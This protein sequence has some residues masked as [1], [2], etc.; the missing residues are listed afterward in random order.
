[1]KTLVF[2]AGPIISLT[3]T[4]MLHI[5]KPLKELFKGR[6]CITKDVEREL[7][8]KPLATKRFEFEALQVLSLI[9]K[10]I[11]EVVKNVTSENLDRLSNNIFFCKGHPMKI[12]HAGEL[13]SLQYAIN[14]GSALVVDERTTR[15]MVED[16]KTMLR[17][18]RK[19]LHC[20]V[21]IN[22]NNLKNFSKKVGNVKIIR[23]AEIAAVA[24]MA[25][26]L[27]DYKVK[28]IPDSSR[29]LIDSVLWGVK[30]N[31]CSITEPEIREITK[32]AINKGI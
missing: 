9:D 24:F 6:F 31:G 22:N 20:D 29:R 16:P 11:I 14:S 26:L 19:K 28:S 23:S 1:M 32:L 4:N 27:D 30:L 2:D 18:L 17:I 25:G 13:S 10:G 7:I 21:K 15:I 12:L 5:L 3:T 8:T